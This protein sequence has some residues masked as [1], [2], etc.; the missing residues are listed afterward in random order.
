MKTQVIAILIF[1]AL[2]SN[3]AKAEIL[4]G[5]I[6]NPANGHF[7]YLL[8]Q[9]SWLTAEAEAVQLGGH[10][11]TI[12]DVAENDWVWSMFTPLASGDR[13]LWLGYSDANVEG[14]FEWVSGEPSDYT[15]WTSGEPNDYDGEDYAHMTGY[16]FGGHPSKLWNDI[17]ESGLGGGGGVTTPHGVA[18]VNPSLTTTGTP[19]IVSIRTA[20]EISWA[21]EYDTLY[22][23][24][25]T[26]SLSSSNWFD[27]GLSTEGNGT[28]KYVFDSTRF[29]SNRFYRVIELE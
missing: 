21:S 25:F 26:E 13:H 14:N 2:I 17:Q 24:Q 15:R 9:S 4:A 12:N 6:K 8:G 3:L 19:I 29:A 28:T 11:V 1:T 5:P 20:S 23:V 27:F 16:P 7:Y 22:Q 18:E 10:L